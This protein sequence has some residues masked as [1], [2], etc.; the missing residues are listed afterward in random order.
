MN[1]IMCKIMFRNNNNNNK[2]SKIEKNYELDCTIYNGKY[3]ISKDEW[4][5]NNTVL[6]IGDIRYK[7]YPINI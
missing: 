1:K 6:F 5:T 3:I 4:L 7:I 2:E